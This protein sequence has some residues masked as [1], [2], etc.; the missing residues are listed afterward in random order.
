M[1]MKKILSVLLLSIMLL[2][3]LVT[4]SSCSKASYQSKLAVFYDENGE[5]VQAH[6]FE[7]CFDIISRDGK[8]FVELQVD[9]GKVITEEIDVNATEFSFAVSKGISGLFSNI[10]NKESASLPLIT[11]AEENENHYGGERIANVYYH[12]VNSELVP[13][14]VIT[15]SI[16]G[17]PTARYIVAA[18]FMD[19]SRNFVCAASKKT[20]SCIS[21][22]ETDSRQILSL[23][24]ESTVTG[25]ADVEARLVSDKDGGNVK[26][27]LITH[28]VQITVDGN[29]IMSS[30]NTTNA[31]SYNVVTAAN[32]DNYAEIPTGNGDSLLIKLVPTNNNR[33]ILLGIPNAFV[34]SYQ[35]QMMGA[36]SS[37]G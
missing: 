8:Y 3:C 32:G 18:T 31:T 23:L 12:K 36:V 37:R 22:D 11:P 4:F 28:S 9:G 1:K 10:F 20:Y 24:P 5:P 34:D 26:C 17:R 27:E 21:A 33:Y 16:A 25:T 35:G 30:Q 6:M 13:V 19:G 2:S 14:L 29:L 7:S 15:D